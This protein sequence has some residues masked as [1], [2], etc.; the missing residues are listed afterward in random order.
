MEDGGSQ[1]GFD[2][3]SDG[4]PEIDEVPEACLPFVDGNDV[5]FDGNRANYRRE[6][7]RLGRSAGRL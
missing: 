5:G 1:D 6:Q 7:K 4:M 2:G 3:M